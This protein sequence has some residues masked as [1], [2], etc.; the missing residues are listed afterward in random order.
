MSKDEQEVK[1]EEERQEGRGRR[2][3]LTPS[4]QCRTRDEEEEQSRRKRT[5]EEVRRRI[6]LFVIW[7][8]E[9]GRLQGIISGLKETFI[10]RHVVERTYKAELRPEARSEKVGN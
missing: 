6:C 9:P 4:Q 8:F 10:K 3:A 2:T 5:I 7:C 1:E